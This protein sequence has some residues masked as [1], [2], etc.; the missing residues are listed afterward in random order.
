MASPLSGFIHLKLR[1]SLEYTCK[2]QVH[3]KFSCLNWFLAIEVYLGLPR[4]R[5]IV[6]FCLARL[7]RCKWIYFYYSL[8][9]TTLCPIDI[10]HWMSV[11]HLFVFV[12][13]VFVLSEVLLIQVSHAMPSKDRAWRNRKKEANE[14]YYSANKDTILLDRKEKYNNEKRFERHKEEYYYYYYSALQCPAL[15][16][17]LQHVL[18]PLNYP[19]L[20]NWNWR[21]KNCNWPS[22][23]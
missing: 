8:V 13:V 17:W 10:L 5:N 15:K 1:E 12:T 21:P 3:V 20:L 23:Q 2:S 7:K 16:V 14:C 4:V 6:V 19:N 22:K 9:F 11:K 18:Q